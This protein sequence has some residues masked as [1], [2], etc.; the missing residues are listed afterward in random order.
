MAGTAGAVL[1][2]VG[3]VGGGFTGVYVDKTKKFK[4]TA[5]ISYALAAVSCCLLLYVSNN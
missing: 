2:A 4:E 5:K 1:I 3:L